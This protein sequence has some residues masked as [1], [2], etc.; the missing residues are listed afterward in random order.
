MSVIREIIQLGWVMV[1]SFLL[2]ALL[3]LIVHR[4]KKH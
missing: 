4:L 3:A 1:F 2:G